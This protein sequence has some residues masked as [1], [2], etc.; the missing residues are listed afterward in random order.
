MTQNGVKL[1]REVVTDPNAIVSPALGECVIQVG[2]RRW[3]KVVW[4]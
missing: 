3:L 4:K 2:P 1:N